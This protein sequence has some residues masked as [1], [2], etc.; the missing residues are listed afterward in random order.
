ML[1]G[2]TMIAQGVQWG[3]ILLENAVPFPIP[4]EEERDLE[5]L[6]IMTDGSNT[7]VRENQNANRQIARERVGDRSH[8]PARNRRGCERDQR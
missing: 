4:D 7:L 2:N 5:Y 6:V 1:S 8:D 3:R